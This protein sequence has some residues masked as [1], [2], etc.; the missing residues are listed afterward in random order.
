VK[1]I[2]TIAG[3]EGKFGGPSRSVPALAAALGRLGADV[4]LVTTLPRSSEDVPLLP[5]S[6]LVRSH[7]VRRGSRT[8]QWFAD[9]AAFG[10]AVRACCASPDATVIH[11]QGLWLA[12][13]HA[14]AVTAHQLGRPR[15]VSP[16]G[17]LST[18]ALAAKGFKK[19]TAW[20]L[21]QRRD[22]MRASALHATSQSEV[23]DCHRMGY[24]GPVTVVGNGTEFPPDR[25]RGTSEASRQS[26]T[27]TVLC[28]GRVHPVKGLST[29]VEAWAR[30]RPP[31]WRLLIA[32]GDENGHAAELARQIVRHNL[33]EHVEMIGE[34]DREAKWAL[35]QSADLFVLP[36]HS[37]NFGLVVAEALASGIPVVTTRG[38]PWS[39]VA[40]QGCGWWIDAGVA[41]LAE[42]LRTAL[43]MPSTELRAMGERGRRL[44]ES[45]YTWDGVAA[46]ML[47]FYESVIRHHKDRR[48]VAATPIHQP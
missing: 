44:A 41:P 23:D 26:A 22:L 37:E 9:G 11:D 17:M 13:N 15:I 33:E 2:L 4:D 36:S 12:S 30:V 18:W 3:L 28:L 40:K 10:R 8:K 42:T 32:G 7:L 14:V 31:G 25:V 46:E 48:T 27:R 6:H 29:L 16:R 1:I 34:V 47:S 39:E 43:T 19:R 5:P 38:T 21:Y 20:S 35:Y 24:R 45:K